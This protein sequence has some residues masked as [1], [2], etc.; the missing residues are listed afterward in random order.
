M[1]TGG[2]RTA[3]WSG[4][5]ATVNKPRKFQIDICTVE[6]KLFRVWLRTSRHMFW[7]LYFEAVNPRAVIGNGREATKGPQRVGSVMASGLAY[8]VSLPGCCG[9]GRVSES[10]VPPGPPGS[11]FITSTS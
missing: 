7:E 6:A 2:S 8:T 1:A 11:F 9:W 5:T 10:Q 4:A 3:W